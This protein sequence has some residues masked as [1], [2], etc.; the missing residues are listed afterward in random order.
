LPLKNE[1][2]AA[3]FLNEA[4]AELAFHELIHGFS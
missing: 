1:A 3:S 4:A 2:A